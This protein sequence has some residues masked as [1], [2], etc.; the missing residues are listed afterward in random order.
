[1]AYPKLQLK[2]LYNFVSYGLLKELQL[3]L[4]LIL[5]NHFKSYSLYSLYTI[6]T[7]NFLLPARLKATA[8]IDYIRLSFTPL[9]DVLF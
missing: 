9:V 3:T 1:M 7:D 6:L 4:L 5:Y 8:Y 2:I